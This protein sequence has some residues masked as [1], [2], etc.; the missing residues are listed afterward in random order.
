[1]RTGTVTSVQLSIAG[2]MEGFKEVFQSS[3]IHGVDHILS[4]RKLFKVFWICVVLSG[5]IGAGILIAQCFQSWEESPVSTTI[6]TRSISDLEFPGVVV[7]PAKN[8]FTTLNPDLIRADK[9]SWDEN[10]TGKLQELLIKAT[11]D[12]DVENKYKAMTSFLEKD[13]F[14]SWYKGESLRNFPDVI[15]ATWKFSAKTSAASGKFSTPYFGETFHEEDFVKNLNVIVDIHVPEGIR[16]NGSISLVIDMDY[17]IEGIEYL[18]VSGS[19]TKIW[20]R[21]RLNTTQKK[22]K[23]EFSL[24]GEEY[25]SVTYSRYFTSDEYELWK[26]KRH[27]GMRVS[28]YYNDT[29]HPDQKYLS[30]NQDFIALVNALHENRSVLKEELMRKRHEVLNDDDKLWCDAGT[31]IPSSGHIQLPSLVNVSTEPVYTNNIT[32]ETLTTAGRLYF[33]F[34]EGFIQIYTRTKECLSDN[35][36]EIYMKPPLAGTVLIRTLI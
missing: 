34:R 10:M 26:S 11:F 31:L 25:Y 36:K 19:T 18:Q 6:E 12:S 22:Y 1:M 8:S 32:Q 21:K 4:E 3:S 30:D 23:K 2:G 35:T 33:Y 16:K 28:W 27:T 14:F 24:Q 7:C 5:F 17:D 29:V 9:N 15:D 13:K 20:S